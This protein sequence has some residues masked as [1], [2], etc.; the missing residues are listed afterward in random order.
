MLASVFASSL[1]RL[2]LQAPSAGLWEPGTDS[3]TMA[4]RGGYRGS[5]GGDGGGQRGRPHHRPP[6]PPW[7]DR[8]QL[9]NTFCAG[10][11][12]RFGSDCIFAHGAPARGG[13]RRPERGACMQ[14]LT[15]QRAYPSSHRIPQ[16]R[17][18]W[19]RP[20]RFWT[21]ISP[22]CAAPLGAP[23]WRS[24]SSRS[25]R[26]RS[27]RWV[28]AGLGGG[29][30]GACAKRPATAALELVHQLTFEKP[31]EP[32]AGAH[33]SAARRGGGQRRRRGSAAAPRSG[34]A[35]GDPRL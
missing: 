27:Q 16:E 12:C 6:P 18:N 9:C 2:P 22:R 11:T 10:Q 3:S 24:G 23:R 20:G 35:G 14:P 29:R 31:P 7:H 30:A 32:A 17:P 28:L 15:H 8:T 26:R 5:G 4:G 34:R 33:L 13:A 25:W 19:R 1:P 21:L